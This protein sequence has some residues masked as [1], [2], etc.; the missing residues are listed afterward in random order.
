MTIDEILQSHDLKST[1]CRKF[2]VGELMKSH[3][4]LSENEIKEQF[5]E[6]FDRV[7][8]YRTLKTLEDKNV[9]HKIVLHDNSVKYAMTHTHRNDENLHSHFHCS[10]CDEVHCLHG[11]TIFE[12]ELPS[13]FLSNEVFIVVEGTC[14]KCSKTL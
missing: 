5:P 11:K 4:A 3:S 13:G 14:A 6:L 1:S 9:I 8:F 10:K 12:T 2:I 7:T